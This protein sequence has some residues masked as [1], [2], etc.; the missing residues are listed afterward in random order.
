MPDVY[1]GSEFWETSLVDPDNR[2]RVDFDERRRVLAELDAGALPDIDDAAAAKL[3]V[4]SRVQRLRRDR[5]ELFTRYLPVSALG[6]AAEHVIAF[7]RG[8][9]VTLATRLPV[10]LEAA[11]GW[12]DTVVLLPQ[13]EMVDVITGVEHQGGELHVASVLGRYPVALLAAS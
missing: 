7:D 12:G 4:T 8:G 6:S 10:G 3:L 1:Q 5:P 13:R 11:G 9:S 2:R